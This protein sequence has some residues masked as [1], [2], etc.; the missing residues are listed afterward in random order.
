M[1][2][3]LIDMRVL[4]DYTF[5]VIEMKINK[6]KE[7]EVMVLF[8]NEDPSRILRKIKT[9]RKVDIIVER[10]TSKEWIVYIIARPSRIQNYITS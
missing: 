7:D 5:K 6:M 4:G 2:S 10:K 8:S 3:Y 9:R 1:K